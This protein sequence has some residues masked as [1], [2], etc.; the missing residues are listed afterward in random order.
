VKQQHSAL[1][2]VDLLAV[3]KHIIEENIANLETKFLSEV[4]V[5]TKVY[6]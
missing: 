5:Q 2:E 1:S 3:E 6:R 4:L